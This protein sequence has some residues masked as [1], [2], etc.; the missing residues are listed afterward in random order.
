[1]NQKEIPIPS[2]DL[3]TKNEEI[4]G[5]QEDILRDSKRIMKTCQSTGGVEHPHVPSAGH[6]AICSRNPR[7]FVSE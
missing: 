4:D 7:R 1:M 5:R 2:L 6:D 3:T